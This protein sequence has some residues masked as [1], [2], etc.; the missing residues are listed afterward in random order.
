[1]YFEE[2]FKQ[3]INKTLGIFS[4]KTSDFKN[5]FINL[6]KVNDKKANLFYKSKFLEELHIKRRI[7]LE[8]IISNLCNRKE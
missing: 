5:K 2:E 1:M 7:L 4:I 3:Y 6:D 8:K